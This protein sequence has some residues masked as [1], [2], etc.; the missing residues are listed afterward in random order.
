MGILGIIEFLVNQTDNLA[1]A[2]QARL[3]E[4]CKV[5]SGVFCTSYLLRWSVRVLG[6]LLT[7]SGEYLSPKRKIEGE[8]LSL[9]RDLAFKLGVLLTHRLDESLGFRRR[10]ISPRRGE[11]SLS[12]TSQVNQFS[13]LAQARKFSLSETT[14]EMLYHER[15][16]SYSITLLWGYE[17]GRFVCSVLTVERCC[18]RGGADGVTGDAEGAQA[19]E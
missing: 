9:K 2:S 1:R 14:L 8:R 10:A 5:E 17:R 12:D 15:V 7:L 16:G 4:S 18:V 19:T 13:T 6:D 3:S 11:T